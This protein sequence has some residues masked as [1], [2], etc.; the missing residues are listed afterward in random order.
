MNGKSRKSNKR[1]KGKNGIKNSK[2]D[3]SHSNED[4]ISPIVKPD[5]PTL[6]KAYSDQ[7][8]H[9]IAL[10]AYL[11]KVY[12]DYKPDPTKHIDPMDEEDDLGPVEYK[13]KLCSPDED[14][15]I[16]LTT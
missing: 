5:K 7:R 4:N 15:L 11:E 16:R 8:E 13:L 6:I 2:D 12:A 10:E 3:P 9:E 14:R 1:N